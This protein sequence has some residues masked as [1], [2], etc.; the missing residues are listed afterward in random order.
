MDERA[1]T[2]TPRRALPVVEL[3]ARGRHRASAP[4]RKAA[5]GTGTG[6]ATATATAPATETATATS[7]APA[8]SSGLPPLASHP[9]LTPSLSLDAIMAG[10]AGNTGKPFLTGFPIGHEKR[11]VT[12]PV[13]IRARLDADEGV[14]T[15][16]E[17][18]TA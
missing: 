1:L 4:A 14:I 5:P 10:T 3:P 15:L 6:T 2:P 13:G 11:M 16:L 12:V 7:P 17:P 18:A 8:T 9:S